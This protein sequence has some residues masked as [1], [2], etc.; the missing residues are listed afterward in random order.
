[1]FSL[2]IVTPDCRNICVGQS[3]ATEA[4]IEYSLLIGIDRVTNWVMVGFGGSRNRG[5]PIA[6]NGVPCA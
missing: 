3:T 5:V 6:L 4:A 1:M 2:A